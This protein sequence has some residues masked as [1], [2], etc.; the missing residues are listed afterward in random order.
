MTP[1]VTHDAVTAARAHLSQH[2][3]VTPLVQATSLSPRL[4]RPVHLK[5]ESGLPT[6]S[7]KVRGALWALA[8]RLEAGEVT[9]VVA[10]STGNHGAAVAWAGN[11]LGVPATIF[12]PDDPN[13]VKRARIAEFGATI[14]ERGADLAAAW[15]EAEAYARAEGLYFLNDATDS[16]LPAG[17]GTIALE[18]L[19][20]VPEIRT[21]VVP[22]GDTAL[23]RGVAAAIRGHRQDVRIVGVQA[24]G[25]P[26]YTLSWRDGEV[27]TTASADTLADGLATRTPVYAN[28]EA[29]RELVDDMLLVS[30]ADILAGV[31]YLAEREGI[32]AE[33]AGAAATAALLTHEV[34]EGPVCAIVSGGNIPEALLQKALSSRSAAI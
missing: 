13:P 20:E 7:F 8:C 33:P 15:R 5:V 23:I 17:P 19:E 27:V 24:K 28:V 6:G 4:G 29:I 31:A 30:D 32:I 14:V 1:S 21:F 11:R 25:A 34:G 3:P 26:A 10:S 16:Q 2:L 12:L 18:V 9:G 22:V